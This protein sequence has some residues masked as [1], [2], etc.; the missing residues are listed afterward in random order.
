MVEKL[1]KEEVAKIQKK[2]KEK[3]EKLKKREELWK[4]DPEEYMRQYEEKDRKRA[5]KEKI[6]TLI[7]SKQ[8]DLAT[9][10]IVKYI[11]EKKIIKSIRQDEKKEVWIYKEGIYVENG[12]SYIEEITRE[13][14]GVLYTTYR[15][16]NVISKIEAD[17]FVDQKEFF[18]Q[19]NNYKYLVPVNN[20]ILNIKTRELKEFSPEY[21]FFNKLNVEYNPKA[22]C[23]NFIKFLEEITEK[24][25]DRKG[26]QEMFGYSMMK[27]YKYEK[28]FM[29][30]GE[31]GRNGKSKLLSVLREFLGVNNCA[32]QSLQKLEEDNFNLVELHNKLVNISADISKAAMNNTGNFKALTGRDTIN[33]QRKFKTGLQFTNYAKMIFACNDLPYINKNENAVW[34]RWIYIPFP[35]QF[36]PDKEILLLSE[37]E[38][39]NVKLQDPEIITKL[40]TEE[41]FSGILNWALEGLQ[42]LEEKKDFSNSKS[43]T[44]LKD[45]WMRKSNSALAFCQDH[46]RENWDGFITQKE[47]RQKYIKYCKIHKISSL[48]NKAI[49]VILESEYGASEGQKRIIDDYGEYDRPKV[50]SGISFINKSKLN[51]YLT[52][53]KEDGCQLCQSKQPCFEVSSKDNLSLGVKKVVDL[54]D[55][56]DTPLKNDANHIL[57]C[58]AVYEKY[59]FDTLSVVT[60]IEESILEKTLEKLIKTGNIMIIDNKYMLV[61]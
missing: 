15:C 59:T 18:N 47:F 48:S 30:H 2:Q 24:E 13:L 61:S 34:L 54:V 42:R 7:A 56:V 29:L 43:S 21:Y 58:M 37:E 11:K 19:Q 40:T 44:H 16:N 9:E 41:E 36:L 17:T 55:T 50:W 1:T 20:G 3:K 23:K 39:K 12:I 25:N 31:K 49:K 5:L 45:L 35:Y 28:A 4:Q 27:E 38:K 33:A 32:E 51:H 60:K 8:T 14:L 57:N 26:I 52:D 10:E 46:I 22:K 6:S 53:T